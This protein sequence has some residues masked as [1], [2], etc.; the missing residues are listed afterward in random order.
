MKIIFFG[1]PDY[2]LPIVKLLD[3]NFR[4]KSNESPIVGVVTQGPKPSGRGK[5]V[6]YSAVDT[7]AYKR[8]IPVY[9]SGIELLSSEAQADLGILASYGEILPNEVLTLFPNG[10][11]NVHPSLLPKFRGP[12][13]IQAQIATNSPIGVSIIKLD[14]QMD[15][16]PIVTQF[17]DELLTEDTSE[18]LK[19]R[20]FERSAEVLVNLIEPYLKGKIN[21]KA[22]NHD[23]ATY[24]KLLNKD[25]GFI[26]IEIL[27]NVLNGSH[28]KV[29]SN[30]PF[31]LDSDKKPLTI[32]HEPSTVNSFVKA[33][34]PWPGVWT[35][36][37]LKTQELRLKILEAHIDSIPNTQHPILILDSV[38]LEGKSPVSWKQF[39]E[40]YPEI[41]I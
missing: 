6:T 21:L 12:S 40:G 13:P 4:D 39:K 31:I 10:I 38:Q 25:H 3:R 32:N 27:S 35:I 19:I 14:T 1:T 36:V 30:F 41:V 7:W 29:E 17:K 8:K 2:V 24:T 5:E 9:H 22:Q 20:L 18:S 11:L 34:S 26:P 15:H 28:L 16:G 23:E 37:K 33:L